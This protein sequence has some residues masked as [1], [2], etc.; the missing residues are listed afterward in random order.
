MTKKIPIS[1]LGSL[2]T[3]EY[4]IY[5]KYVIKAKEKITR[6]IT[7]GKEAHKKLE[8][9]HKKVVK[10][11]NKKVKTVMSS[12]KP[13]EQK[14]KEV[15]EIEKPEELKSRREF[16]VSNDRLIGRIDEIQ[17]NED[18]IVVID[19]KKHTSVFKSDMVQVFAYIMTYR[20]A[21][22]DEIKNKYPSGVK[23]IGKV[24]SYT[25]NQIIWEQEYTEESRKMVEDAIDRYNK[26]L[27]REVE[28]TSTAVP[29]V[30]RSCSMNSLCDR[31]LKTISVDEFLGNK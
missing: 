29:A 14:L 9:K 3:C 1:Q 26:V 15:K 30:C 19:D 6:A 23:F 22:P 31:R 2:L 5:L 16:T 17:F 20:D 7:K 28:P 21:F 13:L 27:N 4:R 25:T 8:K 10:T 12:S 24:R 18:S 11:Y